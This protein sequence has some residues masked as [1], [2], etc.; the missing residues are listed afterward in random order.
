MSEVT[1]SR[2]MTEVWKCKE[3]AW[4]EVEHLPLDEAIRQRLRIAQEAARNLGFPSETPTTPAGQP[5]TS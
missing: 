4:H 5:A 2:A 1:E 3:Q